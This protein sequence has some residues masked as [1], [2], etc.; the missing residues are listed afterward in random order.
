MSATI[1]ELAQHLSNGNAILAEAI[2]DAAERGI[3]FDIPPYRDHDK[4]GR[5]D[6]LINKANAI[7]R[8]NKEHARGTGEQ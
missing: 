3:R 8:R 1:D 6:D 7:I 2:K 4:M 5:L